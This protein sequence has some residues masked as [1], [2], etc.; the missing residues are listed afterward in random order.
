MKIIGSKK[1]NATVK[2]LT[3]NLVH[4]WCAAITKWLAIECLTW[5]KK[6]SKKRHNAN[7]R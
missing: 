2:V 6:E 5:E 7:E 3:D 4:G 1:S